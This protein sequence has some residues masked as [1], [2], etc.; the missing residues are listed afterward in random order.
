VDYG[1]VTTDY[2]KHP[3]ISGATKT[4]APSTC[5]TQ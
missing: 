5:T 2:G 1:M 3:Y 4:L